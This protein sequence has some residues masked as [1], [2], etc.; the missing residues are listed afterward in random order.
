[1]G[2]WVMN[3]QLNTSIVF[4]L[5]LR[6]R[7]SLENALE[8]QKEY[9]HRYYIQIN[10]CLLVLSL[11]PVIGW[12]SGFK[13]LIEIF[14]ARHLKHVQRGLSGRANDIGIVFPHF[15]SVNLYSTMLLEHS[16]SPVPVST[17]KKIIYSCLWVG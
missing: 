5:G 1:M 4:L 9:Q 10:V 3:S 15:L 11:F 2:Q 14:K 12:I 7:F 8:A 17:T 13:M 16:P 6:V